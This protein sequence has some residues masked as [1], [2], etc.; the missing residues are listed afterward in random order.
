MY[1]VVHGTEFRKVRKKIAS[2]L[3]GL[4]KKRPDAQYFALEDENFDTAQFEELLGGQ[5]LFERKNIVLLDNVFSSKEGKE[6]VMDACKEMKDSENVFILYEPTL[7]KK[8][9]TKLSKHA[10]E[11]YEFLESKKKV[12][13]YKPFGLSDAI[14][15]RSVKEGWNELQRAWIAGKSSEEIHGLIF[16]QVKSMILASA[17]SSAEEAGMKPFMYGKSKKGAANYTDLELRSLSRNL[18]ERYHKARRGEGELARHIEEFV[19]SLKK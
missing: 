14:G 16:W 6:R 3:A 11:V 18:V 9:L 4:E 5:G 7:T 1:L 2:I 12:V 10:Y 8:D 19:L 15:K 17:S 13:E